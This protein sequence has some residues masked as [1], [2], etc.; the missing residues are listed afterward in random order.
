MYEGGDSFGYVN[1]GAQIAEGLRNGQIPETAWDTGTRSMEFLSGVLFF[2]TQAHLVIGFVVFG[3]LAYLGAVLAFR[4]FDLAFPEGNRRRYAV[5]VLLFPTMVFWP[6][7][8]SKDSW[9]VLGLGVAMYGFAR[10]LRQRAGRLP[11]RAG[12]DGGRLPD[13]SAHGRAAAVDGRDRV[14]AAAAATARRSGA[15]VAAWVVGVLIF[16]AGAGYVLANFADE[17][18][19]QDENV[20]QA[21]LDRLLER[22]ATNTQTG[23]SQF[24]ADAVDSPGEVR[25]AP[26]SPSRSARSRTRRPTSSRR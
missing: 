2:L 20:Q 24:E 8:L 26:C 7:S 15:P 19:P 23:G 11:A 14:R 6:S 4:A 22:T 1:V 9:L 3:L 21:Q 17:L 10:V 25:P 12:R 13:P 5:L 16:S 18:L